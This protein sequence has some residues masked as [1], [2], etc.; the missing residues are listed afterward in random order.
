[1]KTDKKNRTGVQKA[2]RV[3]SILLIIFIVALAG[4]AVGA[5]G[6][7]NSMLGKINKETIDTN[8]IG[9]TEETKKSLKGYRN[10]ALLGIDSRADDYGLGNRTDCIIIASINEETKDVKMFSVYR[11]TYLE[12]VEKNT[13]KLDKVTHAYSYGGAQN[14]LLALNTNLDLNIKEYVTINFDS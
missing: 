3:I 10:I 13:K 7:I 5:W 9:I 8:A 12:V 1:M 11:D 6:Y 4:V 14:T 2:I